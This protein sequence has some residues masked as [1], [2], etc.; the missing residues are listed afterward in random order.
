VEAEVEAE[1]KESG[2]RILP[3]LLETLGELI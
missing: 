3:P 2:R 1:W